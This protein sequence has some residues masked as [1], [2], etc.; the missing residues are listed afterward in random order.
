M[1]YLLICLSV[2]FML[3]CKGKQG[4]PGATGLQGAT[5]AGRIEIFSGPVASNDFTV[6]D[7]LFSEAS[8]V[9]VYL[10]DGTDV[11]ELPYFL[12]GLG[13][14]TYFLYTPVSDQIRI[15]NASAALATQYL[16]SIVIE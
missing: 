3:G 4:D 9:S 2:V 16:I 1:K 15:F 5:G 7:P 14:N 6:W 10:S 8:I 11:S 13:I 12:P